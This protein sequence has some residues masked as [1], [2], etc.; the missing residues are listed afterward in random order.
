[1]LCH[2]IRIWLIG[3]TLK[4]LGERNKYE[5]CLMVKTQN[6][7]GTIGDAQKRLVNTNLG[8]VMPTPIIYYTIN[9]VPIYQKLGNVNSA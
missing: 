1:V 9:N 3:F 5:M 7:S 6:T 4:I 2:T 8:S